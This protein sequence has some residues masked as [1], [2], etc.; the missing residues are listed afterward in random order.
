MGKKVVSGCLIAFALPFL[1]VGAGTFGYSVFSLLESLPTRSWQPITA[2]VNECKFESSQD[3][4]STSERVFLTYTYQFGGQMYTSN[5]IGI[6]YSTNNVE[7][8]WALYEVLKN[9]HKILVYVNPKNPAK[10]VVVRGTNNST[11]FLFLFSIM[12]N[13]IL[14]VFAVPIFLARKENVN[15]LFLDDSRN[16]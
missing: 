1:I 14:A 5:Q 7:D 15:E 12:W 2:T 16:N 4:E 8:H 13:S 10:A 9:A 11:F 3:S 6:G